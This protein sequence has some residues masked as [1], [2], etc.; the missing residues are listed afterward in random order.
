M[1]VLATGRN[2]HSVARRGYSEMTSSSIIAVTGTQSLGHLN[3]KD[4]PQECD[5]VV[6]LH[7]VMKMVLDMHSNHFLHRCLGSG[8][9]D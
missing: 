5:R 2:P 3:L 1:Q 7:E 6:D 4:Y 9:D 8:F